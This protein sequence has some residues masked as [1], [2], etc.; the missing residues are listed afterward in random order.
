[1]R[2]SVKDAL[3]RFQSNESQ[4]SDYVNDYLMIGPQLEMH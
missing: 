4:S 2:S 1:M 3:Q